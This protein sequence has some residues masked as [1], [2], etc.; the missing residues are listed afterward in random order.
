MR[1]PMPW[2][3]SNLLP[4]ALAQPG[5]IMLSRRP[6]SNLLATSRLLAKKENETYLGG[7]RKKG[8]REG[9]IERG[10]RVRNSTPRVQNQKNSFFKATPAALASTAALSTLRSAAFLLPFATASTP[11]HSGAAN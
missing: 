1:S 8:K 7:E 3:S 5:L 6:R 10:E 4:Y 11:C 2:H 9:V